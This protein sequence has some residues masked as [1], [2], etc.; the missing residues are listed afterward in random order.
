MVYVIFIQIYNFF[1]FLYLIKILPK[2][3]WIQTAKN[4]Q[5]YNNILCAELKLNNLP[6]FR[7]SCI[8]LKNYNYFDRGYE[9]FIN[10]NG[11]FDMMYSDYELDIFEINYFPN[12][13]WINT[14]K[15]II[16]FP[17]YVCAKLKYLIW[18]DDCIEYNKDDYLINNYGQFKKLDKQ[19]YIEYLYNLH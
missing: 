15:D 8:K 3:S 4:I 7:K 16:Y 19:Q 9:Y 1:V 2:G 14:A 6:K 10:D 5:I 13:N 12:G 17:N 11:N 18:F